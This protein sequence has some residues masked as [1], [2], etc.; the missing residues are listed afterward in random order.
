MA[1]RG[2]ECCGGDRL[3]E[4]ALRSLLVEVELARDDVVAASDHADALHE[5]ADTTDGRLM[6]AEA[7]VADGRVA[8]ARGQPELAIEHFESA[9]ATLRPNERPLLAGML[10]LELAQVCSPSLISATRRT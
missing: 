1:R 8:A 2:I 5:L 3:R 6:R 4:A 10:A 9:R 7:A